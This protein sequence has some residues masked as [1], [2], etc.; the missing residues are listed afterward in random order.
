MKE[1]AL[2][3]FL[4]YVSIDTQSDEESDSVPSTQ[5]QFDL[6]RLLVDELKELGLQDIDLDE[7]CYVMATLP[8]NSDKEAPKV[9]FFAHMDTSPE[10]C[11]AGVKARVIDTY[12]GG[13]IVLDKEQDIVICAAE[14]RQ[15]Q[16]CVGD[17][18]VTSDGST[19]LGA[20]D[21]AGIAAIMTLLETLKDRPDIPHGE[22]KIAFT[23]DEEIGRGVAHFDVKKFGADYAYTVDGGIAGELNME[24]F[25]ANA[26]V[27]KV[28]GCNTHPGTAKDTMI[29]AIR[30]I[31]HIVSRLPQDMAPETTQGYEPFIHPMAMTGTVEKASVKMILRDFNTSGL[32]TQKKILE[33]IIAEVQA[34]YP[35]AGITLD[36]TETYRNMRDV[37]EKHPN[38]TQGLFDAAEKAGVTPRWKPIRGGTDGSGLT[39]LGL[40]TPNIFSGGANFHSKKEWLSVDGLVKSIETMLNI[41]RLDG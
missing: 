28:E 9:G 14:D 15:L 21:K 7:Y 40:P 18:L 17:T 23:P 37:L 8:A 34:L 25:S 38:V 24:T 35:K 13:D 16:A 29:N 22:L 31:C 5:V 11:G 12:D 33:A 3:R 30:V 26:A 41:V 10:M 4:R 2:R 39:A 1:K 20:D 19:L 32:D 36:I 27:I 6:A